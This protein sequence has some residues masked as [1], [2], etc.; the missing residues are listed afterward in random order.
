M[1]RSKRPLSVMILGCL[2]IGI[3][4][5][6]FVYHWSELLAGNA[7][8]QDALWVE[9]TELLA[10]LCGVFVLKGRN[11]ARWA[12]IA[13]MAFHVVISAFDA[14][15]KF[16]IHCLFC[17]AIAW[18]LFRPDATRYFERPERNQLR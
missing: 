18:L 6:G 16:V 2:Y 3:G 17:A 12:A 8:Q 5:A 7:L 15:P 11:W 14:W 10:I 4:I 9:L 13:W 1:N